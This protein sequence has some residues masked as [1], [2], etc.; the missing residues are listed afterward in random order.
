M[1]TIYDVYRD[2]VRY[3]DLNEFDKFIVDKY[4]ADRYQEKADKCEGEDDE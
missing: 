3:E 2:H 4:E 1:R